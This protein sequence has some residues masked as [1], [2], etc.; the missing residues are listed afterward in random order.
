MQ[1][2]EISLEFLTNHLS[3]RRGASYL[4]CSKPPVSALR[5]FNLNEAK[6]MTKLDAKTRKNADSAFD[7]V[8]PNGKRLSEAS[9]AD[10]E[11]AARHYERQ[12]ADKA[13]AT[14][15]GSPPSRLKP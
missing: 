12:A 2:C 8:L 1:P 14:A 10:I 3:R 5:W 9:V 4:R 13:Q 15:G 6:K 7:E 11:A